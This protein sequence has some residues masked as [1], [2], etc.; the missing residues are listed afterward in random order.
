MQQKLN[1]I[2]YNRNGIAGVGFYTIT[3]S[4]Q[5]YGNMIASVF[6][7]NGCIAV[8]CL[9]ALPN[10]NNTWRG[11]A[12]ECFLRDEI[13]KYEDSQIILAINNS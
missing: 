5:K 3:F 7:Q 8:Y 9:D 11:D 6:P 10:I 12:Y 1:Q 4:D 13:E 2:R